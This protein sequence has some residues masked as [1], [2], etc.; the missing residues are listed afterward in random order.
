MYLS[1]EKEKCFGNLSSDEVMNESSGTATFSFDV[2]D[3]EEE[4]E[5]DAKAKLE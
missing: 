1:E 3:E 2:D 5:E 4:E